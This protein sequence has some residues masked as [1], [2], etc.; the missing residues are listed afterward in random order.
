[1]KLAMEITLDSGVKE[2]VTAHFADFIAFEGEKNRAITNLQS[3]VKLSDLAWLAWHSLKRR[4]QVK[5]TF[6]EWVETVE[7]L[8][9]ATE[10]SVIVPLENPQPTG[11]SHI[12]PARHTSHHRCYYKNHL[13]CCTRWSAICAGRTSNPTRHRGSNND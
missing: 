12:S 13:E 7:S 9:V 4:N 6:M 1:M 2:K 3:E 5:T 11:R 8:E 10:D